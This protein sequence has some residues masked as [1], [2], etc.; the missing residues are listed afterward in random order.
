MGCDGFVSCFVHKVSSQIM[1]CTEILLFWQYEASWP[2]YIDVGAHIEN[3]KL[4]ID[5]SNPTKICQ[6]VYF[7][8]SFELCLFK[9]TRVIKYRISKIG[10][11]KKTICFYY[12]KLVLIKLKTFQRLKQKQIPCQVMFIKTGTIC[13]LHSIWTFILKENR[14]YLRLIFYCR[15]CWKITVSSHLL[16]S[17]QS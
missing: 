10:L 16:E 7:S 15:V 3:L 14:S 9:G 12:N 2:I 1:G 8:T 17:S 11:P 4:K 6:I 13:N 5:W